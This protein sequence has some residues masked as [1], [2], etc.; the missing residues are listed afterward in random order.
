MLSRLEKHRGNSN[1]I[2]V[3]R[4][5]MHGCTYKKSDQISDLIKFS[6]LFCPGKKHNINKMDYVLNVPYIIMDSFRLEGTY[7]IIEPN[8]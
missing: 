4:N 5:G 8:C 6:A 2:F 3:F 7:K 1:V